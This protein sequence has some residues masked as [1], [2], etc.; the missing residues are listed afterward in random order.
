MP[1]I[2]NAGGVVH[3]VTDERF[4]ELI[5]TE[6]FRV[7]SDEE[8]AADEARQQEYRD[9]LASAEASESKGEK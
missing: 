2:T 9:S 1:Y 4:A 3:S 6:G 5:E 8:I 7:A